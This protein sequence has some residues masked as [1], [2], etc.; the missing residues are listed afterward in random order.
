MS[1]ARVLQLFAGLALLAGFVA[2][3]YTLGVSAAPDEKSARDV[4]AEA[5]ALARGEA[6]HK[7]RI[8]AGAR[9]QSDGA[10]KGRREGDEAGQAEGA[11]RGKRDAKAELQEL[12]ESEPL[13]STD[14]YD[15]SLGTVGPEPQGTSCPPPYSYDMGICN[16]SRPALPSE[17]PSGYVPAGLT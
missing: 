16:I 1:K 13:P 4:H 6:Q 9:G 11:A 14:P 15:Y 10:A 2:G 17:C 5:F 7:A 12:A 8:T 3:G